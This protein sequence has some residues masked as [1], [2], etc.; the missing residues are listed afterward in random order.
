VSQDL[1]AFERHADLAVT[2]LTRYLEEK[3]EALID[4]AR[5]RFLEGFVLYP[6]RPLFRKSSWELLGETDEELADA[7]VYVARMLDL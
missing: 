1:A 7:V 3:R 2:Y 5:E 4:L 6:D